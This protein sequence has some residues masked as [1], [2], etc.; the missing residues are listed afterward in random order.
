M[1]KSYYFISGLPRS[2]STLLSSIL[3]QNP[4]F[5]ADVT[6]QIVML[7]DN[8]IDMI[9]KSENNFSIKEIQRQNIVYSIFDGYYKHIDSPII[10]DTSRIWTQ[11]ISLLQKLFPYTKILCPVRDIVS[12]LNSFE[13]AILKNPLHKTPITKDA[14]NVFSRCNVLMDERNGIVTNPLISL[15]EGYA[16]NPEVIHFIEYDELCKNPE[17]KM[18]EIY[19]FLEKPYYEHDFNNVEYTNENFDRSCNL[20]DLHTVRK[21]VEYNQTKCI[22]PPEIIKRFKDMNLEFWRG[23]FISQSYD[24]CTIDKKNINYK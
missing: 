22:L 9:S 1:M 16:F 20:K 11:K 2:G 15:K 4:D 10:F 8:A 21:K 23:A 18:R 14:E 7:I 6:S 5:Y 24:A 12:I 13:H 19:E 3:R 17:K